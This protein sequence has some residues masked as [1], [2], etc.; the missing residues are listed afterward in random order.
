[1]VVGRASSG[2]CLQVVGRGCGCGYMSWVI[3]NNLWLLLL[4]II[5]III[6]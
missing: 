3:V 6:N 1:M 4:L 2:S 5:I